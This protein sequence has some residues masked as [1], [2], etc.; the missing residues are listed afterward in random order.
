MKKYLLS[1]LLLITLA[2]C[3]PIEKEKALGTLERDRVTFSATANEIIRELPIKEG[4]IVGKGDVLVR[5]DNKNQQALLAHAIAEQAKADAYLLKL[6]NG[7]RPED[8]AAAQ[9]RVVRSQA[10]LTE[11]QKNYQRK[12]ELVAKKL[13]SQSEKDSAL[14]ARDSARAELDSANEE[15]SKLTAGSRPEDIEQA[16]AALAAAQADV[17]LQQQKLDE[18]TIV[19]TRDGVLDNLPY[20]LGERV[21]VNGIVAVVQASQVP[22]ARVYVPAN[23][24]V[25]FTAGKQ[26]KVYVDGVEQAFDGHVRWV[27]TEPSFTPYYALTEEERSRLMYLAEV[28]LTEAAVALP[29]GIAAQ[30]DLSGE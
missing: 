26:V 11:A 27:S 15:F 4:S 5:L 30:V 13:I 19:A 25:S 16:R 9:A 14:A 1:T 18:L 28:D 3:T 8:I 7:E 22:Y 29:S 20:N 12:A 17:A 6:T 21:P 2:A 24:R 23:Y 10:Q